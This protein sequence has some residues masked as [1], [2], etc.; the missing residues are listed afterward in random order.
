MDIIRAKTAGF[1]FGV[2]RAVKTVNELI[3]NR[4]KDQKIYI[5]GNLIHNQH[6][7]NSLKDRGVIT[8]SECDINQVFDNTNDKNQSVVVMRT[9][10]VTR[11][12]EDV[13]MECQRQNP[14]F[15]VIDCTC[16][17]VKKI[18]KID[19]ASGRCA[20]KKRNEIRN[21]GDMTTHTTDIQ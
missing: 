4:S 1:C 17:F 12:V 15:T 16:P 19:N 3:E 5:L 10:G 11:E 14:Y 9:H 7:V 13:L 6:F 21:E 2:S 8:I 18:H 20:K